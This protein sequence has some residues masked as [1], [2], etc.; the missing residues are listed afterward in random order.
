MTVV[1]GSTPTSVFNSSLLF[2]DSATYPSASLLF[3]A[4]TT[5]ASKDLI[6]LPNI[7]LLLTQLTYNRS[8]IYSERAMDVRNC[9]AIRTSSIHRL[10]LYRS[11]ISDKSPRAP[12]VNPHFAYCALNRV[13]MHSFSTWT[14]SIVYNHHPTTTATNHYFRLSC[15]HL[16]SFV[17][18]ANSQP[19][20]YQAAHNTCVLFHQSPGIQPS[21]TM[22]LI[23]SVIHLVLKLPDAFIISLTK[24][25]GPAAFQIFNPLIAACCCFLS[26]PLT[27]ASGGW[28][29]SD[30]PDPG[31]P[32]SF[33]VHL[34]SSFVAPTGS[35]HKSRGDNMVRMW[36]K[37]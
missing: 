35:V 9:Q 27:L 28:R 20:V 23:R 15:V 2:H 17:T 7:M 11:T 33:S 14:P 21:L 25:L 22:L 5:S 32:A 37:L 34:A 31:L 24:P 10:H 3:Q 12:H 26:I 18:K 29:E 4:N 8:F 36:V 1:I 16:Q 13:C 30:R 6:S 19:Y